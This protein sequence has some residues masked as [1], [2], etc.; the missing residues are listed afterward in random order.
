MKRYQLSGERGQVDYWV[1][2]DDLAM[3]RIE[4]AH[5]LKDGYTAKIFDRREGRAVELFLVE[6]TEDLEELKKGRI[7]K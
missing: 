4:A 2:S 3:L 5:R 6:S 7:L 1:L